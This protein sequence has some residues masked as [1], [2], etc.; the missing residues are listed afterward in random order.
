MV[1]Y[2]LSTSL[3]MSKTNRRRKVDQR[4]ADA[5]AVLMEYARKWS[6]LGL[7]ASAP[8]LATVPF[9]GRVG[10]VHIDSHGNAIGGA[11]IRIRDIIADFSDDDAARA[12]I[13]SVV[14]SILAV[15]A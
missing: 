4:D 13:R 3:D 7:R 6:R 8:S 9:L 2:H 15:A 5:V 10:V 11:E 1:N 14:D 12:A